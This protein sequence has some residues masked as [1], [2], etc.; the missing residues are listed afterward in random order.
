MTD[1]NITQ[2]FE[3][4]E[5]GLNMLCTL[6]REQENGVSFEH[7]LDAYERNGVDVPKMITDAAQRSAA[8]TDEAAAIIGNDF[9][10]DDLILIRAAVVDLLYT[11]DRRIYTAVLSSLNAKSGKERDPGAK[12]L[13]KL[14]SSWSR[15]GAFMLSFER[16]FSDSTAEE[17]IETARLADE[18]SFD[19]KAIHLFRSVEARKTELDEII[20]SFSP[21][22]AVS[23]IGKVPLALLRIAVYEALFT[24]TPVNIAVSEAVRLATAYSLE[25]EIKF[26]NGLLGSL[27]KS[28][29]IPENKRSAVRKKS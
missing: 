7:T 19:E 14:G 3:I 15:E 12:F 29:L 11:C 25:N 4:T 18:Y 20:G 6:L 17:I 22:R 26:V 24:D 13:K 16:M 28:D 1:K 21:S 23:R 10:G 8:H 2:K 27:S 9:S 5:A